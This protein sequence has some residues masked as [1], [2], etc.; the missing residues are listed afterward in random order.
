MLLLMLLLMTG[1]RMSRPG[2]WLTAVSSPRLSNQYEKGDAES[3]MKV[4]KKKSSALLCDDDELAGT[5]I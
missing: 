1:E 4:Q 5:L 3:G 2:G